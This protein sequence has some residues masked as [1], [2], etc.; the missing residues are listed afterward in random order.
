M[1]KLAQAIFVE[2][3]DKLV[4]DCNN[5]HAHLSALLDHFLASRQISSYI[6]FSKLHI[7]GSKHFF[8]RVAE[9]TRWR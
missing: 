5:R 6:V 1:Q 3:D 4:T 9:M 2:A 8:G 7:V